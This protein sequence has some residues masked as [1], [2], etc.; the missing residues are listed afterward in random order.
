LGYDF[1]GTGI[2]YKRSGPR[3]NYSLVSFDPFK[4]KERLIAEDLVWSDKDALLLAD[5]TYYILNFYNYLKGGNYVRAAKN[6]QPFFDTRI[7]PSMGDGS[8]CTMGVSR[9]LS[10]LA[11]VTQ[12]SDIRSD[13]GI[14]GSATVSVYRPPQRF[15]SGEPILSFMVPPSRWLKCDEIDVLLSENGDRVFIAQTEGYGPL[16]SGRVLLVNTSNGKQLYNEILSH[17]IR[18]IFGVDSELNRILYLDDDGSEAGAFHIKALDMAS[19]KEIGRLELP[20]ERGSINAIG[21]A[22]E[23][24][25]LLVSFSDGTVSAFG[26][27]IPTFAGRNGAPFPI[28]GRSDSV[29]KDGGMS[30]AASDAP[31]MGAPL[32]ESV[33]SVAPADSLP[34]TP[35]GSDTNVAAEETGLKL[36]IA[37][38]TAD[39]NAE[40]SLNLSRRQRRQIQAW[41]G[42]LGFEPG[43]ADGVFG[44]ATRSSIQ[45]WQRA[46]GFS[47]SGFL[48]PA[49]LDHMRKSGDSPA[50][51]E[52]YWEAIREMK[53][54]AVLVEFVDLYPD[55][56]YSQLARERAKELQHNVNPDQRSMQRIRKPSTQRGEGYSPKQKE[57]IDSFNDL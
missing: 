6:G 20:K 51:Q 42:S 11:V 35:E 7:D 23:V 30:Q 52:I 16:K 1:S 43:S 36:T 4:K 41:L 29:N 15:A 39:A 3:S 14:D 28:S 33:G 48:N 24:N 44:P 18:V 10:T 32:S 26:P 21:I 13:A 34:R 53:N 2:M 38:D 47:S 22:R 49:Q 27:E 45:A 40:K 31:V 54:A 56:P 9:D 19:G 37:P 25:V 57:A 8:W 12:G 17:A 5:D 46:F 50:A 55:G